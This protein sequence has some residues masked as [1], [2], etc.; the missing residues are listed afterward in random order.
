[1]SSLLYSSDEMITAT[2]LS[3]KSKTVFDRFRQHTIDKAVVLHD[4]KPEFLMMRFDRYEALM[5]EMAELKKLRQLLTGHTTK[6]MTRSIAAA[7]Q[8]I[9]AGATA[10]F[11]TAALKAAL[12]PK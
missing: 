12:W 9:E 7:E 10:P 1:M 3:R 11:D 4:G 2:E 6:E 5:Q 8:E